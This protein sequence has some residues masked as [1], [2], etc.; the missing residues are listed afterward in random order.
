MHQI[1][2]HEFETIEENAYLADIA[3]AKKL[4]SKRELQVLELIK[5]GARNPEIADHFNLSVKTV[6]N[7]VRSILKKL[8]AKNRTHA[9]VNAL[10]LEILTV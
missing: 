8:N 5:Q 10:R 1:N 2:P 6:E 7:H 3:Q 4:I 9:V